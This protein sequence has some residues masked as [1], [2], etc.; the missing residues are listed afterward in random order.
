MALRK[1]P[2]CEVNY[3]RGDAE[4]CDVCLRAMKRVPVAKKKEE[5]DEPI[6]CTECG[7]APAVKGS[8]LCIECLKEQKRQAEL[9]DAADV[10]ADLDE[11]V[12]LESEEEEDVE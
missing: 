10:T 3:I 5:E 4:F 8:D 12:E 2:K 11:D 6:M 7:E 1:C 9:E